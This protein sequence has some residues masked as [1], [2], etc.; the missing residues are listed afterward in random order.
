MGELIPPLN[1]ENPDL[2]ERSAL[3]RVS[4]ASS[5]R[6]DV[7]ASTTTTTETVSPSTQP[8]SSLPPTTTVRPKV[9]VSTTTTEAPTTTTTEAPPETIPEE[10]PAEEPA[11]EPEPQWNTSETSWYGPGF[12]GNKTACGQ[13]YSEHIEGV[14]HKTLACGTKVTFTHNGRTVTVPVIDRG[15]YTRGRTWDLSRATCLALDHCYTG[16]IRWHM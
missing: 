13:T 16:Q 10:A 9:T 11:P 15:P 4:R 7:S 6:A 5:G 2:V 1:L 12:Y 8:P 14:A 3:M